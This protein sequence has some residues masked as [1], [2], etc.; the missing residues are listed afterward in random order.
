MKQSLYPLLSRQ[1]E[2]VKTERNYFKHE[3]CE[4]Y[5]SLNCVCG[6]TEMRPN[7]EEF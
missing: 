7:I 3:K 4:T 5:V 2:L 6:L 1:R